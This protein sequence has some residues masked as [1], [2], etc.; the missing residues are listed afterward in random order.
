[1]LQGIC[2]LAFVG[3]YRAFK[4]EFISLL[5]HMSLIHLFYITYVP[6]FQWEHPALRILA[7]LQE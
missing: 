2:Q 1:M 3:S 4:N 7:Q 6:Y 5:L